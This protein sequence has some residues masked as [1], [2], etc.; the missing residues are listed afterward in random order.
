[1]RKELVKEG[2]CE[3]CGHKPVEHKE[4]EECWVECK[5]KDCLCEEY[6]E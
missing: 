6:D 1:M 5:V 3:V 2:K 4:D